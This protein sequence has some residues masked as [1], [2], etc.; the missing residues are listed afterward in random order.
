[1]SHQGVASS[2]WLSTTNR[3]ARPAAS[4]DGFY[5]Q[6]LDSPEMGL[7]CVALWSDV[8]PRGGGTFVALDSVGPVS[9]CLQ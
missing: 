5:R 7:L 3:R 1:L 9:T 6:F 2:A 4:A 8:E